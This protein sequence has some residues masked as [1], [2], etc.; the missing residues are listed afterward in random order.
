M[1]KTPKNLLPKCYE[2]WQEPRDFPLDDQRDD[3]QWQAFLDAFLPDE[4]EPFPE[5]GDFGL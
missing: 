3:D 5:Q 1:A 2:P 4:E